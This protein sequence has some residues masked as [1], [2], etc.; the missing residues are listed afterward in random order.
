MVTNY[1]NQLTAPSLLD[2]D[3]SVPEGALSRLVGCM[4]QFA[5]GLRGHDALI[6]FEPNRLYL[7]CAT[8]G[9]ESQGWALD[10][11]RPRLRLRGDARRFLYHKV[12]SSRLIAREPRKLA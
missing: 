7:R 5:C 12:P 3:V 8:C 11:R 4:R 1:P 6:Q 2:H 9:H 10:Q